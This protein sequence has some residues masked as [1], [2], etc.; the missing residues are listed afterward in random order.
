MK[1]VRRSWGRISGSECD[2]LRPRD[3][4]ELKRLVHSSRDVPA[5]AVGLGRSYGD[6]NL[7]TGGT[8]FDMTGLDRFIEIDP[9]AMTLSAEAGLSL[10]Q[11]LQVLVPRGLFLPTTPGTRYVTLGGAIANDVHGKNHHSAGTFGSNVLEFGLIRGG[12]TIETVTPQTQPEL[13]RATIGGLG[14]T[15]VIAWVK[16]RIVPITSAYLDAEIIP[17]GSLKDFFQ[18]AAESEA[19]WEHTVAWV[20]CLAQGEAMG[21]GIFNR[22]NYAEDRVFTPHASRQ[23]ITLPF[24]T[25]SFL[26]NG[27]SV[28]AFNTLYFHAN[29]IQ[30]GRQYQHYATSFHPLDAIGNWNLAYGP[31]GFYQYQCVVPFEGGEAAI[32]AMLGRIAAAGQGSLL[33]VLKTFG[34]VTSPGYL[35]FPRPGVTLALD[36]P[37]KGT[38]TREL[39]ASLDEIVKSTGG[40]LY[41]AKDG[42]MDMQMVKSGYPDLQSFL[43]HIEPHLMSDFWRRLNA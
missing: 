38:S 15:G 20:D 5:L 33:A 41:P 39:M 17:F 31:R 40:R 27:L 30:Q 37:N 13:F 1:S 43:P 35:S 28:R 6:T 16:I 2:S 3:L 25:P 22:A 14:L 34:S 4:G 19:D 32:A 42:R 10:D 36:F 7:N 24:Q 29:K 11:A 21:R 9:D 12:G 8:V 23:K 18:L 26:L